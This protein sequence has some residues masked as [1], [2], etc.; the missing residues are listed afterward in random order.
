MDSTENQ[1]AILNRQTNPLVQQ[2]EGSSGRLRVFT[3]SPA[4][5]R[6]TKK[7]ATSTLHASVRPFSVKQGHHNDAYS[8]GQQRSQSKPQLRTS[9]GQNP[10]KNL[11]PYDSDATMQTNKTQLI[12]LRTIR[13]CSR[14]TPL[15]M[16]C[17]RRRHCDPR[18][19]NSGLKRRQVRAVWQ[20]QLC[21]RPQSVFPT[22]PSAVRPRRSCHK[23]QTL[24]PLRELKRTASEFHRRAKPAKLR[25]EI[26][27]LR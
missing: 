19:P 2:E 8:I 7:L 1:L 3:L 24:F 17:P 26:R 11:C 9:Q 22:K 5:L 10:A 4:A 14:L 25:T 27:V 23:C 18:A 6:D 21:L 20:P 12:R 13:S 16:A 15:G